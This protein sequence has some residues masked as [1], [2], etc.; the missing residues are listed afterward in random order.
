MLYWG[1]KQPP[2]FVDPLPGAVSIGWRSRVAQLTLGA[3]SVGAWLGALSFEYRVH[4]RSFLIALVPCVFMTWISCLY[5]P[6]G[7]FWTVGQGPISKVLS[8]L[9]KSVP[10]LTILAAG[11]LAALAV[12]FWISPGVKAPWA[13]RCRMLIALYLTTAAVAAPYFFALNRARTAMRLAVFICAGIAY[14]VFKLN[15]PLP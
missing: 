10:S 3:I 5:A 11:A 8:V 6:S 2:A 4:I 12:S 15:Q 9:F 7:D 1:G 13:G 14:T